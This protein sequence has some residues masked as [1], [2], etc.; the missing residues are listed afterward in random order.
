MSDHQPWG[1]TPIQGEQRGQHGLLSLWL[2]CVEISLRS[3]KCLLFCVEFALGGRCVVFCWRELSSSLAW[4]SSTGVLDGVS[5]MGLVVRQ[6]WR[7]CSARRK[8]N[9]VSS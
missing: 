2:P 6:G 7:V 9:R 5:A 1:L 8:G 3:P 4:W